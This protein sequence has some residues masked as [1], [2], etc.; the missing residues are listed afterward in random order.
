MSNPTL[1][2]VSNFDKSLGANPSTGALTDIRNAVVTAQNTSGGPNTAT[3]MPANMQIA[4]EMDLW[5]VDPTTMGK[6]VNMST[7]E[8]Q[9]L[10]DAV[11]PNGK[12]ASNRWGT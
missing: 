10:Y 2:N 4:K 5:N 1:A 7:A 9:A 11:N 8:V 3:N 6:A 12:Y